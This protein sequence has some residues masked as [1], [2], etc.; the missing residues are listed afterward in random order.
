MKTSQE[1]LTLLGVRSM[2][3][4]N[5]FRYNGKDPFDNWTLKGDTLYGYYPRNSLINLASKLRGV[6]IVGDGIYIE[7]YVK[8]IGPSAFRG[9]TSYATIFIPREV[10]SIAKNS[11]DGTSAFIFVEKD[12]YAE[13]YMKRKKLIFSVLGEKDGK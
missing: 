4:S 9:V 10:I 2:D 1:C 11:F 3:S 6:L 13:K 8:K 12:S 7:R 5:I